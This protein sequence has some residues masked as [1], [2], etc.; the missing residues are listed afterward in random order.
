MTC[1]VAVIDIGK[2]NA[3]LALVDRDTLTEIAVKTRPNR[4]L[5]APPWPHVDVEGH[6]AFLL[7]GLRAFHAAYGIDAISVTTHGACI[8]LLDRTGNLA[9][10]I[11]DYEHT[12]PDELA[13][14]YD[15][16]RP[17]FSETG[18]PRLAAGLNIGAQLFWQ[19]QVDPGLKDRTH[20]IVT[21]PQYWG[22]RL[23]GV[24]AMDVTSL[25]CHSDLWNPHRGEFSSLV[26][27]LGIADKLPAVRRPSDV[28]GM[29]LP[30]IAERASLPTSTPVHC[31]IHDSNASLLPYILAKTPP[32]SVIST[33]TWAIAMSIG[34]SPVELDPDLDTLI[35]VTAL[36]QPAPS[37]RFMGGREHDL[38]TGGS[39]PDPT[40]QDLDFILTHEIMLMP[41]VAAETGPF[42][43]CQSAWLGPEPD[44][45]TGKR[46]AAVALYLALVTSECLLNICHKGSLIVEGPFAGNRLFLEMLSVAT[47]SDVHLS[48]GMTGTSAGAALLVPGT[49][50][51]L[52]MRDSLVPVS[53][54]LSTSFQHYAHR[55]RQHARRRSIQRGV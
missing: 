55:W 45:G 47:G 23:S 51:A 40:A 13:E 8:A 32:F 10:P 17:P 7:E 24:A 39:Y 5:A 33:G 38:A 37:A 12:G 49:T 44:V 54:D 27:S 11:L 3:K 28:L 53:A 20:R 52:S 1:H 42:K 4:V 43:G 9:A 25:G 36:D 34:G 35:N 22:A 41:A 29:I 21:Y 19:F 14:D 31:G 18:S 15:A 30:E 46:G 48:S 50:D 6:W 16:I 2:T 26:G